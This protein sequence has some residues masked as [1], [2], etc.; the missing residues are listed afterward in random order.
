MTSNR[1]INFPHRT[2]R[3]H[4]PTVDVNVAEFENAADVDVRVRMP[5]ASHVRGDIN[6]DVSQLQHY[7]VMGAACDLQ[8]YT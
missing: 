2:V 7:S 5:R 1:L 6:I 3:G 4:S 8:P